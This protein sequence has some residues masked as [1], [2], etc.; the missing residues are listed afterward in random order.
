[1][2]FYHVPSLFDHKILFPPQNPPNKES[3]F[4]KYRA[5]QW[6]ALMIDDDGGGG[7]GGNKN[8]NDNIYWALTMS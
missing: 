5:A 4:G 2:L 8:N 7:G 3:Y 6:W 1:M